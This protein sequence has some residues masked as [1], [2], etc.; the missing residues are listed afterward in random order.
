MVLLREEVAVRAREPLQV[1]RQVNYIHILF[2]M[3]RCIFDSN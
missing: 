1:F 3:F 2:F